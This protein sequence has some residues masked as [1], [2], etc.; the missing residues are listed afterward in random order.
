MN[1]LS[2]PI[3]RHMLNFRILHCRHYDKKGMENSLPG[4]DSGHDLFSLQIRLMFV[5]ETR[6]L[7]IKINQQVCL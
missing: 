2:E 6:Q 1:H 5:R 4:E 3:I 7:I